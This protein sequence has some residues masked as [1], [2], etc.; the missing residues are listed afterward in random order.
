MSTSKLITRWLGPSRHGVLSLSCTR[1][2]YNSSWPSPAETSE[3]TVVRNPTDAAEWRIFVDPEAGPE[4]RRFTIA[5]ELGHFVLHRARQGAFR[6][7]KESVHFGLDKA[8]AIEREA[9]EFASNILMPGDVVRD[10]IANR[11]ID[12]KVQTDLA[13]TFEVS[14][15]A[16]CI[17]FIKYTD[18]RAI[19]LHWD[20]GFLT[21]EW[22]SKSAVRTR[23]RIRRTSDPQE[24]LPG[25]LAAD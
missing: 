24:P 1:S 16:P 4:R 15:E 14:F 9:D 6:C 18:Q 17:R 11:R 19:L 13:K 22:R 10:A 20:N 12:L 23:A 7:D 3:V 2:T 25:T 5:H 8:A 21:Y